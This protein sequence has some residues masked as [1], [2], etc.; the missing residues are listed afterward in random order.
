MPEHTP[1]LVP[2][3]PDRPEREGMFS[4]FE[5]GTRILPKGFQVKQ[6]FMPLPVEI[7]L[8]KDVA[9]TLRDGVTIYI[10]L[11]R[12]AGAEKIPVIVAWS[13]YGK[14]RGNA[15]QYVELY[16]ML[17]MDTGRLSGLHKFEGPDPAFWCPRG[18]PSATRTPVV[19]TTPKAIFAG[20]AAVRGRITM[21]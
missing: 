12:P 9:V 3:F 5:P 13:P 4:H 8:D 6:G 18:M 14:N 2:A 19:R 20:G 11:L 7:V 15:S 10:D 16:Q 21:I 1:D 17:G